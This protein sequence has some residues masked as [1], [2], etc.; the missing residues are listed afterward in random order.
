MTLKRGTVCVAAG[1]E[2]HLHLKPGNPPQCTIRPGPPTTGH[3]P[4]VDELF[5]SALLIAASS[6]AVLLTGMGRDGAAGLLEL[7]NAGS[8]T[9]GQDAVTSVVYGMPKAAWEIGAVQQQRP[10]LEIAAEILGA[11]AAPCKAAACRML[12]MLELIASPM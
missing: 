6:V 2:G 4:Y 5:R 7:R 11:A 10:L 12:R 9:I 8:A 3:M 1:T